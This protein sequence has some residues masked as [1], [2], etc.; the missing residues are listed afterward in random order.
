LAKHITDASWGEFI[1]QLKYKKKWY[2]CQIEE[3]D[4][5]LSSKTRSASWAVMEDMPLSIRYWKC[6]AQHERNV[7]VDRNIL[8]KLPKGSTQSH[9]GG[10]EVRPVFFMNRLVVHKLPSAIYNCI[11]QVKRP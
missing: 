5:Y 8:K 2:G 1:R 7:T 11:I 4:W 10:V 9:A 3:I 6:Q